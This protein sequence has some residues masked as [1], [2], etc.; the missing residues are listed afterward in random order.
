MKLRKALTGLA[1]TTAVSAGLIAT[2]PGV[3]QAAA[4]KDILVANGNNIVR[5]QADPIVG[6][7][8]DAILACDLDEDAWGVEAALDIHADGTIDRTTWRFLDTR[9]P[10]YCT[11]WKSGN[12]AEGTK[13]RLYFYWVR[14]NGA[15]RVK[16]G[17]ADGYA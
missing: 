14:D 16:A 3:A 11:S 2:M 7:P 5:F 8:G 10:T 15:T 9:T 1:V 17:Y 12:I 13:V 6:A 4:S